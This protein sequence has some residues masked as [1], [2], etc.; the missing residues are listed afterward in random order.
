[1]FVKDCKQAVAWVVLT[2][3][4]SSN[5]F[6]HP[7]KT[8][9]APNGQPHLHNPKE[10]ELERQLAARQVEFLA[11]VALRCPLFLQPQ[12]IEHLIAE[13]RFAQGDY[14]AGDQEAPA[15]A[16]LQRERQKLWQLLKQKLV[17]L[18]ATWQAEELVWDEQP[19]TVTIA[20]GSF[21]LVV[22][23]LR[24]ATT[25]RLEA[26]ALLNGTFE[27]PLIKIS[28]NTTQPFLVTV[29]SASEVSQ[30]TFSNAD[31][32]RSLS[33]PIKRVASAKLRVKLLDAETSTPVAGRVWV[34]ASDGRLRHSGPFADNRSFLEK[35]IVPLVP[36]RMAAVPFFYADGFFEI[37]LPPGRVQLR[38]ER[39]FEHL[40][41]DEAVEITSG[42]IRELTLQSK[43][44]IDAK[45]Q[46]WVSGDTHVHWVT[47]AWNVDL[48]LADLAL[49]QRAEDLRVA[50]NLTL[51][52][53]THVDAFVKPSQA[54]IGPVREFCNQ[55]YHL[56]MAE[57]YRNQNLYGHL[58]FLNLQWLVLPIGTGPQIAGEDS[59]DY[60]IN[61]TAI[62]EARGQGG[63]SIEA[64]GTGAN[65]EL[66]L[67]AIH[68]LT[69]SLDQIDPE[70]YYRLLDCGFQLPLTNGSDHPARVVGCARAYVQVDG[71]F[72]YE[73]WIDGIRCGRTF[74]TSG[75]L[76]F[77]DIENQAPGA[78]IIPEGKTE[79]TARVRAVS[80]FPLGKVQIVSNGEV[81]KE[82][83]SDRSD[84][85]VECVIPSDVSRWVVARCSRNNKFN[86]LWHTDIAHTSAIY[87]HPQGRTV[88]RDVAAR[89]WIERMKFHARDIL[90][91]GRFA[92]VKQRQEATEYV[93]E[94]IRRY[95][96][97]IEL[98]SSSSTETSFDAQKD[99]LLM[100]AATVSP[101]VHS[102]E[103]LAQLREQGDF[104]G[105][106]RVVE[107][108]TLLKVHINP[109]SRVKIEMVSPPE[110]IVQHRTNRFLLAIHNEAR[111][112]A[113][114]QVKALDQSHDPA[115]PAE[116]FRLRMVENGFS[117]SFLSG[118]EY[119]WKVIEFCCTE[120]GYREVHL[121][122][123]AGQG[124]QDLGFRATT[125]FIM[126]CVPRGKIS[127]VLAPAK[128]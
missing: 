98:R 99:L 32:Q 49:V 106:S 26:A 107:S 76:L 16:E 120:P 39:G 38:F 95:Q 25:Q 15:L 23:E 69:D 13:N 44:L 43:R 45:R 105:L 77:L 116:W 46:G 68:G 125:D 27:S 30:I 88:F 35:T 37:E 2:I 92:N 14:E 36:M 128:P 122:A 126:H 89:E 118:E 124:T 102:P 79:L 61:K 52:H 87:I 85:T 60:P 117:T 8:G 78:V 73:K 110:A 109:E 17:W 119:E 111:I 11:D 114:L 113:R 53:R 1:M 103:L 20:E 19:E 34:E 127:S 6:T 7:P 112:Q 80:R 51:L 3:M 108:L 97:L 67:N 12:L 42:E 29:H 70:D 100:Q 58:C 63:I 48:P 123:E 62:L 86:A 21:R 65:H 10:I 93:D 50:N 59:L 81:I 90:T 96:R 31:L 104:R 115:K 56:E 55:D 5:G 9:A 82:V 41:S 91:K 47:N 22:V 40:C 74:T 24:N 18:K 54:P 101:H 121:E 72:D 84:I 75:P 71:E 4:L 28:P 66:P 64:H 83:E 57:E 33:L 94:A